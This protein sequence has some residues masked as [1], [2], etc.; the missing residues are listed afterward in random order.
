MPQK[1]NIPEQPEVKE[2]Q[3]REPVNFAG[4]V[5]AYLSLE[6]YI[7]LVM[8]VFSL[9]GAETNL[10]ELKISKSK[11]WECKSKP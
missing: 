3:R 5:T 11:C 9:H 4:K 10:G 1:R 8:V 2:G 6:G 7:N